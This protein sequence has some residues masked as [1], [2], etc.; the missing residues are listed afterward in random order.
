MTNEILKLKMGLDGFQRDRNQI[1]LIRDLLKSIQCAVSVTHVSFYIL[2]CSNINLFCIYF[3]LQESKRNTEDIEKS[4]KI[5]ELDEQ[6]NRM[7][8]DFE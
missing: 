7:K 4:P 6:Y 5:K 1:D 3:I 8:D 2:L